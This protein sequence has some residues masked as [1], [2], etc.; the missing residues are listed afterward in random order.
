MNKRRGSNSNNNNFVYLRQGS[1][2]YRDRGKSLHAKSQKSTE[3]II[4]EN[5]SESERGLGQGRKENNFNSVLVTSTSRAQSPGASPESF[6]KTLLSKTVCQRV[7]RRDGSQFLFKWPCA[8]L[9]PPHFR[10]VPLA[11]GSQN[12]KQQKWHWQHEPWHEG[13]PVWGCVLISAV[14]NQQPRQPGWVDRSTRR[15]KGDSSAAEPRATGRP[16]NRG[17]RWGKARLGHDCQWHEGPGK[18]ITAGPADH[19]RESLEDVVPTTEGRCVAQWRPNLLFYNLKESRWC[20]AI[21]CKSLVTWPRNAWHRGG[22]LLGFGTPWLIKHL[23]YAELFSNTYMFNPQEIP[24]RV[25][26]WFPFYVGINR[27][28]EELINL[29]TYP[30]VFGELSYGNGGFPGGVT[31]KETTC[32]SRKCKRLSFDLSWVRKI[33]WRRAFLPGETHGQRSLAGYSPWGCQELDMTEVT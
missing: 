22:I 5:G 2:E 16:W 18:V 9:I 10:T 17:N 23:P 19:G 28:P 12:P 6:L 24:L 25:K 21:F 1:Q 11:W 26:Q 4:P 20:Q 33:T 13:R 30:C 7:R 31:G 29:P 3:I 14:W 27:D 32:Q 8:I 15:H